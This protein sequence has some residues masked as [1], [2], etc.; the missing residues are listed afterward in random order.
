[1]NMKALHMVAFVLVVVGALNWGLTALGWNL[2]NL[3]LGAWP[4]L[5]MVVYLL[6][7]V[8]GVYLLATHMNDC[9]MCMKK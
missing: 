1:M 7:G 5:E 9:K 3:L 6:V 4:T 8:S 2:V